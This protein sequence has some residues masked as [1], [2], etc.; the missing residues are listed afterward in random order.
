MWKG[1]IRSFFSYETLPV[2]LMDSAGQEHGFALFSP[3]TFRM[4]NLVIDSP[5]N[6]LHFIDLLQDLKMPDANPE[7]MHIWISAGKQHCDI[8]LSTIPGAV[9]C[10]QFDHLV[11]STSDQ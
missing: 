8:V 5:D 7:W 6:L 2:L 11:G 3:S 9:L 4:T 1:S 10:E